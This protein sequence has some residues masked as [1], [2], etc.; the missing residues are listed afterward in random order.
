MLLSKDTHILIPGTHEYAAFRG[1][2][3]L[4]LQ[5]ELGYSSAN[6]KIRRLTYIIQCTQCNYNPSKWN[7]VAEG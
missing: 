7:S 3:E 4:R 2:E 1:K 6:L 5:M